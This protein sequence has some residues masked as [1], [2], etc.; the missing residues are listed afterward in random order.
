MLMTLLCIVKTGE[1]GSPIVTLVG[2]AT[3][4]ALAPGQVAGA[5]YA[6]GIPVAGET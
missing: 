1:A 3:P 6:S 5:D 2:A 4:A